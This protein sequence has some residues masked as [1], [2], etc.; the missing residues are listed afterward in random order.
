MLIHVQALAACQTHD[1]KSNKAMTS[2]VIALLLNYALVRIN[3][4]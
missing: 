1:V 4:I 3:V 2:A